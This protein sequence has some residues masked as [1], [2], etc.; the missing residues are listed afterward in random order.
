VK[1]LGSTG[2]VQ[3]FADANNTAGV[4]L[5]LATASTTVDGPTVVQLMSDVYAYYTS[6]GAN[7]AGYPLRTRKPARLSTWSTRAP[8]IPSTRDTRCCL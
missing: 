5:A 3:E 8:S 2:Y 1:A 4:K 6:V 7:T